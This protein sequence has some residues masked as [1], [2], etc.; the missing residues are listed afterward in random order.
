ML[1]FP[2]PNF[3]IVFPSLVYEIIIALHHPIGLQHVGAPNRDIT[4]V[5]REFSCFLAS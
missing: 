1:L 4:F 3:F 5:L 2:S